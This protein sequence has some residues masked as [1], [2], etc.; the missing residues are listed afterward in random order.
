MLIV[1]EDDRDEVE[2]TN[3]YRDSGMDD[4]LAAG[5]ERRRGLGTSS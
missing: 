1:Y 4:M 5:I 2:M 3:K